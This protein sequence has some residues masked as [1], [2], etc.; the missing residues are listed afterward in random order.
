MIASVH[1][2]ERTETGPFFRVLEVVQGLL[3]GSVVVGHMTSISVY[4][5]EYVLE[6]GGTTSLQARLTT[7]YNKLTTRQTM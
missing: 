7:T 2:D 5:F 1:L 4:T 6:N 3:Q